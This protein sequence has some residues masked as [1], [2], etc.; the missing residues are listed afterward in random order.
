MSVLRVVEGVDLMVSVGRRDGITRNGLLNRFDPLAAFI[1]LRVVTRGADDVIHETE[2]RVAADQVAY[3]AFYRKTHEVGPGPAE[4]RGEFEI[5]TATPGPLRFSVLADPL[6]VSDPLG[7]Y[8]YPLS[9]SS[10]FNEFFFYRAGL[11]RRVDRKLIGE[12]LVSRGVITPLEVEAGLVRQMSE[13]NFSVTDALVAQDPVRETRF[14]EALARYAPPGSARTHV[15]LVQVLAEEGL[16]TAEDVRCARE[17]QKRHTHRRLG[18]LLV[19]MNAISE[20]DVAAALAQKFQVPFLDIAACEID[21]EVVRLVPASIIRR[22]G[23]LPVRQDRNG[24]VIA[25]GDPEAL[26]AID[27]LRFFI[28][29]RVIEVIAAPSALK[30]AAEAVLLSDSEDAAR[31]TGT[32]P[33]LS[34]EPEQEGEDQADAVV[35]LAERILREG[36]AEG[37]SDVHIEPNGHEH[38]LLVRFRVDGVCREHRRLPPSFRRPLVTRLKVLADLDIA[39]RRRPQ[40][41]KIR[42]DVDGKKVELRLAILPTEGGD[43]D[44]VLRILSGGGPIPVDKLG[45]SAANLASVRRALERP[46]G[47]ILAVGPT[48]S[49]KTTTLHSLIA[50]INN[51]ERKIWTAEDPIE[52]TQAGLR[53]VQDGLEKC[54]DGLT[55][56][57][58]VLAV[59]GE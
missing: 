58:Q 33:M 20:N 3:L 55:D 9:I 35:R 31:R 17:E 26:D 23:V 53:Q 10:V 50:V 29:R 15:D 30:A 38:D 41:G 12:L 7:F 56:L 5:V 34:L 18:E 25:F 39:E 47:L 59:C 21:P 6:V 28:G 4:E 16:V 54:L 44:A 2:E 57:R 36:Y 32:E 24:V 19:E 42:M 22:Y 49:G 45:L 37:A 27:M 46:Y 11:S 43:E 48:G 1:E 8:A 14:M 52:I 13:R 51:G 40:D